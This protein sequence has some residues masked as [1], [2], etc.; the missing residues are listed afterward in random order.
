M[1]TRSGLAITRSQLDAGRRKISASLKS[2]AIEDLYHKIPAE[3]A[4]LLGAGGIRFFLR[5]PLTDELYTRVPD[6]K[7]V[8]ETRVALDPSSVVGYAAMTRKTSFAW[9]RDPTLGVKRYVVAVPVVVSGDLAGVMELTHGTKDA[10]I[11][12]DRLKIFNELV[13]LSG[14]RLQEIMAESVRATPYD[15]L[16]ES[17]LVTRDGLRKAREQAAKENRSLEHILLVR[18]GVDKVA[19]GRSLAE[20]FEV[21]F[22]PSPG[23][24][25]VAPDLLRK[26]S[27]EFLRAH[28]VLPLGWKGDQ[29]EVIVVNPHNLTLIDDISRQLGTER[30][31][32]IVAVREDILAALDKLVAPAAAAPAPE[33]GAKAAED[34]EWEP[35][36]LEESGFDLAQNQSQTIDSRTIRLVNDTIQAAVDRG[37][38]DIHLE[39]TPTGGL[40]IRFRVDGICHDYLQVQEA[41]ARPVVSRLKIMAQL[42]IA[43]HRLPQDGKIRLKDKRG[44]KTDLRVAI[45]PTHGGYEDVVLRLLPEYQVLTLDQIGM[46]PEH[47]ERFRKVIEQPHGIVLCVGPTGSGKTTTLHAALAHVKGPAVKVWTAEDPIEITQEGIRQV[48]MHAQIGLT[49]DRALRAFLRCDPDVVMIG[50]IRDRETADAAVEASLTGHLVMS[51][52]HTNS[53]PE[54]VTRLLEMGL[55]SFTFGSSL[56]GVL[57]QR[58]VRRIC[59]KCAESAVPSSEEF[60][61]L[62]TQFG[63]NARFDALK[64]DRKRVTLSRG[65]GCEACFNTGYRGRVGIHELLVVTPPVRK[66]VQQKAQADGILKAAR[67]ACM[68]TLKQDGIR[69]ILKGKTDL[70]EVMSITLEENL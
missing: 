63:D 1:A 64:A 39:T 36:A 67:E 33:K 23:D 21:P 17:G 60:Q 55:D 11:D 59:D 58:L 18:A 26:F 7:R 65:K 22:S 47:L 6:G 4:A 28:A 15:Y 14:K 34:A 56:L 3:M 43:E 30:L 70:K 61:E 69:K 51:T 41:C 46:E 16:I 31:S 68:L 57:A 5:D 13:L 44:R 27:P 8:R 66:L 35:L 45:M 40:F 62:K 52:L 10:V 2:A 53:A 25:P 19:L 38:S 48:Q 24:R 9:K 20:H 50:E 37:A 42:N 49:F 12:E 32:L 29:V 54:T